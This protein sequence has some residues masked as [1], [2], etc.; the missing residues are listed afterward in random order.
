MRYPWDVPPKRIIT[1]HEVPARLHPTESLLPAPAPAPAPAPEPS[2]VTKPQTEGTIETGTS[3]D[4]EIAALKE[5]NANM[6]Q[7]LAELTALMKTLAPS[8]SK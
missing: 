1:V 6:A 5:Q 3:R 8:T 4:A 2:P 7:Q